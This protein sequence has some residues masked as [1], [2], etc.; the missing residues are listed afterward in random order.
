MGKF[1]NL[2]L[3]DCKIETGQGEVKEENGEEGRSART[4][5]GESETDTNLAPFPGRRDCS[6][7]VRR[8]RFT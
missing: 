3:L 7:G 2:I 1:S 8:E 6:T 4:E 5:E